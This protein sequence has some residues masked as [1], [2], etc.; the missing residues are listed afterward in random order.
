MGASSAAHLARRGQ[1]VLGLDAFPRGHAQGA[2]HGR[3]RIFREAYFEAPE[4]VPLVQ[5]AY[6]LWRDLEEACGQTLLTTTGGLCAGAADANSVVGALHSA[7]LHGLPHELLSAAEVTARYPGIRLA[8]DMVGL[9]EPR[10]GVL[11]ADRCVAAYLDLAERHGADMHHAE[12]VLNWSAEGQGVRVETANGTYLAD[13]LVVTA[14]PWASQVLVDLGL[15]LQVNRVVNVHFEPRQ[16]ER[17][18]ADRFPVF[19]MEVPE[20]HYYG[21]PFIAGQGVKI[22]RHD[23]IQACTPQTIRRE[24]YPDE[25]ETLR[26]VLDQYLPGAAGRVLATLTCMYTN[27]PDL[28]FILDRHPEHAQVVYGCGFSGHGFKFAP[29]IGEVLSDL[30]VDGDTSND[31]AFLRASRLANSA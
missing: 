26:G 21:I 9:L 17:F 8:E 25:V 4:Y 19:V 29:V 16:P 18:A 20:G 1:R 6:K 22:G 7:K 10:A 28:H 23:N 5:R 11:H 31:V 12:L 13:R 30:A 24:I 15:P 3:S 2:S 27:T 14:G